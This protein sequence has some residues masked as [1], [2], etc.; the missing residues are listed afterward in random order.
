MS[1]RRT[2]RATLMASG[3]TG[4]I[5]SGRLTPALLA[6]LVATF[7][8]RMSPFGRCQLKRLNAADGLKDKTLWQ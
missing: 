3:S 6:W 4:L 1:L 5:R 8:E 2:G 7:T